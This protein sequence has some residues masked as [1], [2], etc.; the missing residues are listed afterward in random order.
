MQSDGGGARWKRERWNGYEHQSYPM[1][2]RCHQAS[3]VAEWDDIVAAM[4]TEKLDVKCN[5]QQMETANVTDPAAS[6][7]LGRKMTYTIKKL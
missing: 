4:A 5:A 1:M 7:N 2:G 3:T 6:S